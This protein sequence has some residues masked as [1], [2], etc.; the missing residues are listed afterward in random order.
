MEQTHLVPTEVAIANP[1]GV[2]AVTDVRVAELV[3]GLWAADL[4]AGTL[5]SPGLVVER[6]EVAGDQA[7]VGLA[8]PP[9]GWPSASLRAGDTVMVV[10]TGDASGV[11]VDRATVDSVALLGD[12][13]SGTRLVTVAVPHG[14]AAE[15]TAAAAAGEV[16]LAVVP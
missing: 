10:A 12:A 9:G 8:L 16:A 15:V 2:L 7:L 5:L 11:L 1:E 3:G 13:V 6:L 4:P 14:V